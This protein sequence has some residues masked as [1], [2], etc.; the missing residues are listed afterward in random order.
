MENPHHDGI[1]NFNKA[2]PKSILKNGFKRFVIN[3]V[4][5]NPY[6]ESLLSDHK[7][8]EDQVIT[9]EEIEDNATNLCDIEKQYV[10]NFSAN[11]EEINYKTDEK[12]SSSFI[13]NPAVQN[14]LLHENMNAKLLMH[15]YFKSREDNTFT[16]E[17]L[18]NNEVE[19][20]ALNLIRH[21]SS[22]LKKYQS[23][24]EEK[25]KHKPC[26]SIHKVL[27]KP[28]S[29]IKYLKS[30]SCHKNNNESFSEIGTVTSPGSSEH[31][32]FLDTKL[33]SSNNKILYK[34]TS[35]NL[36]NDFST[37]NLGGLST[38]LLPNRCMVFGSMPSY[39]YLKKFSRYTSK[40]TFPN[41]SSHFGA[42]L[43]KKIEIEIDD[44][45]Y[46]KW[47]E[48]NN[49]IKYAK[50]INSDSNS[51]ATDG[52]T[53]LISAPENPPFTHRS[54]PKIE[55]VF[56]NNAFDFNFDD[57]YELFLYEH[58]VVLNAIHFFSYFSRMD[59]LKQLTAHERCLQVFFFF[60]CFYVLAF[61]SES[62]V[63][64]IVENLDIGSLLIKH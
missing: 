28:S 48:D 31:V 40:N 26:E 16:S 59:R 43:S 33:M 34:N 1:S 39:L 15:K 32:Q 45:D 30:F 20:K 11:D 19:E 47:L 35:E 14:E 60:F 2:E 22:V 61:I 42:R 44:K 52:T 27:P 41:S 8:N 21:I 12:Y 18:L 37:Y 6:E 53:S 3:D 56:A 57:Y 29:S 13:N 36:E 46:K 38:C 54:A 63:D 4:E 55:Q 23:E 58:L 9:R 10:S 64:R 25:F 5:E 7:N 50:S 51:I 49:L 17:P 62:G 24:S